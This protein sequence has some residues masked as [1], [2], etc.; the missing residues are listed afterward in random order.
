MEACAHGLRDM[1]GGGARSGP[2]G[3]FKGCGQKIASSWWVQPVPP[4]PGLVADLNRFA[5]KLRCLVS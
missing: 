3:Q 1:S 5:K 4:H 2:A